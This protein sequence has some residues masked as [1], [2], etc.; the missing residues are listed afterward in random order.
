MMV[1]CPECDADISNLADPCPK[2]GCPRAGARSKKSSELLFLEVQ[3]DPIAYLEKISHTGW[4]YL[5]CKSLW[6]H[7]DTRDRKHEL[8]SESCSL[9][10]DDKGYYVLIKLI[11]K[12]CGAKKNER[13]F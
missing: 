3:K 4:D 12:G 11:C 7:Y 10:K 5:V 6:P 8:I 1:K 9:E 13:F 2:C